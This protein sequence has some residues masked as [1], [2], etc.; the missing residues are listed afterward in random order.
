MVSAVHCQLGFA[1]HPFSVPAHTRG[2]A[3]CSPA[4]C[5][6]SRAA[7]APWQQSQSLSLGPRGLENLDG[8]TS[9]KQIS[10]QMVPPSACHGSV[11]VRRAGC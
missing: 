1:E 2:S 7:S 8:A 4:L 9:G 3:G 6:Q 5:S 10:V 11:P